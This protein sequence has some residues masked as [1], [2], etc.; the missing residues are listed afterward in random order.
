MQKAFLV[1]LHIEWVVHNLVQDVAKELIFRFCRLPFLPIN[2][3]KLAHINNL[4]NNLFVKQ[5]VIWHWKE[6]EM[7]KQISE[8][9]N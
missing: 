5:I 3:A 8:K 9:Q 1:L 6:K 7:E 2:K 4:Y